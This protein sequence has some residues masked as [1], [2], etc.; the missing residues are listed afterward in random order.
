[1]HMAIHADLVKQ[2]AQLIA[3][4]QA[5]KTVLTG[6]VLDFLEAWLVKHIMSEDK[7]LGEFLRSKG[8][9]A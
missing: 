6:A 5:G 8:S 2:V 9:V 3:D 4:F 1:M 7:L